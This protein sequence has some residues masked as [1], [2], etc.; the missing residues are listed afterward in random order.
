MRY[1][2]RLCAELGVT[3]ADVLDRS[4][5]IALASPG[6]VSPNG[7]CH[8]LRAADA[9]LAVNLPRATDWDLIPAWLGCAETWDAVASAIARQPAAVLLD[10]ARLLGLPVSRVGEASGPGVT[11]HRR[12]AGRSRSGKLQVLD[13]SALW[14]GP[15]CGSLLAA[16]GADVTKI[17]TLTRPDPT[18]ARPAFHGRLNGAKRAATLDL[19]APEL[20]GS[21]RTADIIITS[22][23]PRAF[24]QASL[25]PKALFAENPGLIWVAI[26]GYGWTGPQPDR[27]AF[28]DDAAAAGGLLRWEDGAPRFLGD[29][30]AD[31]LSGL[32]A[33]LGA[34]QA[35]EQGG[36]FLVDVAMAGVATEAHA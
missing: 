25:A 4:D 34:L 12:A 1:A 26:S 2:E 10:T 29:A 15:L 13:L 21:L 31:P 30:L 7:S 24:A 18:R 6:T 11:L 14:A 23:R 36:G 28:G 8:L 17:E 5:V 32:A 33:T 19:T 9:W 22:A 20:R 27:V 35:L 16:R 3:L